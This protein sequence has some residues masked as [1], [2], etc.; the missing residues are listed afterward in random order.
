MLAILIRIKSPFNFL[1]NQIS[2]CYCRSQISQLCHIFKTSVI[3]TGSAVGQMG[4]RWQQTSRRIYLLTE[5]SPSWEAANC[6]AIQE[7]PAILR[8]PK[9]HHRVHKS[10]PLDW[11][12]SWASPIR[13]IPSHPISLRSVLILS[14]HLRLGLPSGK[15]RVH[16]FN[17]LFLWKRNILWRPKVLYTKKKNETS[18]LNLRFSQKT[19]TSQ[20]LSKQ[21]HHKG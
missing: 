1:L 14:T 11:S 15:S 9:V 12:L 21:M 10:P 7:F 13:S 8:N 17:C 5:L 18:L 20:S 6:A 2:L 4:Q 3:F 16:I 19:N